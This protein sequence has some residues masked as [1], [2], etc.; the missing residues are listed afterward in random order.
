MDRI[1]LDFGFFHIYWYSIFILLGV[2]CAVF[3]IYQ[4]AKKQ[5]MAKDQF[6][7]M[8]FYTAIVAIIGARLYYVLFN[9]NF[10][11]KNPI[12]IFKIWE[13]GLAIHGGILAGLIFLIFYCKKNK[14]NLLK[15]LD[16]IVIGLILGQA[17]GR[18]GN[19]F[20]QEAYGGI[21]TLEHL[22]S[23]FL[24]SFIIHGMYINGDYHEPTFFYESL[25]NL[26]GFFLLL[27]LRKKKK[28]LRVGQLTGFYFMWYSVA[29]FMIEGMRTDS[30]MLGQFRIAQIVSIILFIIGFYFYFLYKRKEKKLYR[31]EKLT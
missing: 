9:L 2:L 30:L 13:G 8:V 15:L 28:N 6:F 29:R 24:P 23:L 26:I 21:T 22:K 10:Y 25:W 4:E 20:N 16:I 14:I 12:H 7:N 18:W 11:Q 31:E 5:G 17:I 3:V 19:F 27:L 1:A